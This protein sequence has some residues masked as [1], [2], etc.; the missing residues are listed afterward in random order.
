MHRSFLV[1]ALVLVGCT[2]GNASPPATPGVDAT[3]SG[4]ARLYPYTL[5]W[6]EGEL[7]GAWRYATA[8]WDGVARIDHGN[9]YT[10]S[11]RTTDGDL[12]AFGYET[13]GTVEELQAL[14]ADQA[15]AS[16]GCDHEPVDEAP[17]SGGSEPG[18]LAVHE[19]SGRTV[20]R[21]FG[22]HDGFGLAVALI[23]ALDAELEPARAQFEERIGSLVWSS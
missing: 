23:V 14:I 9:R 10:D 11:V 6:P 13:D 22:V 19:C 3:A 2:S 17:L 21:W 7:I 18:I 12:F 20:L 16:H 4:T 5:A 15:T 8:P 1:V